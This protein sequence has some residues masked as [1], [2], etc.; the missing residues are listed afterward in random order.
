VKIVD[1]N[2]LLY[3]VNSDS[4]HHSTILP[5]W[6][7]LASGEEEIGFSW[8]VLLGFLRLSTNPGVFPHPLDPAA[9][10]RKV[11]DWLSLPAAR[12][13]TEGAEHWPIL[14]RLLADAG[15]AGNL[16]TDAHLAALAIARGA[17]LVSCDN[18]F[19]RFTELRRENPLA[20]ARGRGTRG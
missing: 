20:P 11:D 15:A 16:T 7:A 12:I 2:V 14:R 13:V 19:A 3:A 1:L 5:Y 6:E 4:A 18:D 17:V 10:L 8:S 9:A